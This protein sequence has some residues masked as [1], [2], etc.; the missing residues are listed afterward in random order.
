MGTAQL[1]YFFGISKFSK[2]SII[3][4]EL[5]RQGTLVNG[6]LWQFLLL[7]TR[8]FSYLS[9]KGRLSAKKAQFHSINYMLFVTLA[10][11]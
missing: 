7:V 8:R 5:R 10:C 9:L 2:L 6:V 11:L 1:I 3:R 4:A